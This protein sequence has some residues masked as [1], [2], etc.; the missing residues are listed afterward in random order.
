MGGKLN[1]PDQTFRRMAPVALLAATMCAM[2]ACH[3]RTMNAT[4]EDSPSLPT[5]TLVVND[6]SSRLPQEYAELADGQKVAEVHRKNGPPAGD[7]I[8]DLAVLAWMEDERD[9]W[10]YVRRIRGQARGAWATGR[11]DRARNK[12]DIRTHDVDAFAIET[13]RIPVNW[14][15]PVVL[16]ID[17]SNCEL[18]RR[19]QSLILFEIDSYGAWIVR[20]K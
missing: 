11:F 13:S 6:A 19:E 3:Q 14:N 16:G 15:R 7:D 8:V 9:R 4:P 1:V 20:D 2:N 12:I 18:K 5:T 10:L 17:G